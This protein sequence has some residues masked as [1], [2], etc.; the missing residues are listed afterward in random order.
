MLGE[1]RRHH[2][3]YSKLAAAAVSP[4]YLAMIQVGAVAAVP[5]CRGMIV[6]RCC[7]VRLFGGV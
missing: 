7:D 2:C 5:W 3:S 1:I 4:R 6:V